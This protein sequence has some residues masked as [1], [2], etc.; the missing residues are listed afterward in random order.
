MARFLSKRE[1]KLWTAP[2]TAVF[3]G[4]VHIEEPRVEIISYDES[5]IEDQTMGIEDWSDHYL[6]P[7][8]SQW[9]NVTGIHHIEP[10]KD[11][12]NHLGMHI[13]T[14]EDVFNS[15]QRPKFEEHQE[16]LYVVLRMIYFDD[17]Q[18]HIDSEQISLILSSKGLLTLQ[19][20]PKD[21]FVPVRERLLRPTT[22]IRHRGADYLLFALMDTIVDHYFMVAEKLGERIETHEEVILDNPSEQDQARI[23]RYKQEIHLLRKHIRPVKEVVLQLKKTESGLLGQE[24]RP[25]LKELEDNLNIVLD[26]LDI[27][28]E[29]LIDMM[30]LYNSKQDQRLNEIIRLLT[31]FSVIF[32]PLTFL[33]GIY[34]TNFKY[35]PELEYRWSYPIFWGVLVLTAAGMI[36]YFRK[37]KWF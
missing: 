17:H 15:T 13:L 35:L 11:Y 16:Y 36:Y 29:Q 23:N 30:V 24:T 31:V 14:Q 37:N 12:L 25:F 4:E 6:N 18:E 21:V 1:K 19:E 2:G 28:R 8:K 20:R 34:G 22:R 32:I 9:V 5:E 7:L 26:A 27:Y 3:V 33:A 10:I